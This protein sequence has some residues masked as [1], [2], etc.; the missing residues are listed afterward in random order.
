[1]SGG[2]TDPVITPFVRQMMRGGWEV[3]KGQNSVC[4][5]LGRCERCRRPYLYTFECKQVTLELCP[6]CDSTAAPVG[7][8]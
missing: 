1:M 3:V 2:V 8:S 5:K 7:Q 4:D 6:W